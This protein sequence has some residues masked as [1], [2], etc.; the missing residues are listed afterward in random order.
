[1]YFH[2]CLLPVAATAF[3]PSAGEILMDLGALAS[4]KP[5]DSFI[6]LPRPLFIVLRNNLNIGKE[7]VVRNT[8]LQG[9]DLVP[10]RLSP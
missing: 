5:G 1:M 7:V 4:L 2:H 3:K 6:L 9:V 10:G 8:L